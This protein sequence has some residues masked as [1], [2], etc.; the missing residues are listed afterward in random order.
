[1]ATLSRLFAF[2][3]LAGVLVENPQRGD[4]E[5]ADGLGATREVRL[6]TSPPVYGVDEFRLASHANELAEGLASLHIVDRAHDSDRRAEGKRELV[7]RVARRIYF[8]TIFDC[9]QFCTDS[10]TAPPQRQKCRALLCPQ[11][12]ATAHMFA[13]GMRRRSARPGGNATGFLM[14]EPTINSKYLQLLK[15][16]APNVTRVAVMQFENSAWRGDFSAIEA[17]AQSFTVTPIALSF[18]M[19]AKSRV[20]WLHSRRSRTAD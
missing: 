20:R 15:D 9:D 17:V 11:D 6:T 2:C 12:A 4:D 14:F 19:S 1:V 16:M 5:Q 7:A 10:V 18:V 8:L 3:C 13:E